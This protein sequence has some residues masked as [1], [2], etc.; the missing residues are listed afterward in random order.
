MA[1][2]PGPQNK[3][4]TKDYPECYG[5]IS[6]Q[7]SQIGHNSRI[8]KKGDRINLAIHRTVKTVLKAENKPC[9]HST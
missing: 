7:S 2:K 8:Y 4:T 9:E 1:E 6:K 5:A 3:F